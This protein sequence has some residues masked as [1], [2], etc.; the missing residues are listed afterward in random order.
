MLSI[1]FRSLIEVQISCARPRAASSDSEAKRWK[2]ESGS[3]KAV[4]RRARKRSVYHRFRSERRA[5]RET[6]KARK[7]GAASEGGA[8]GRGRGG[9]GGGW[10]PPRRGGRPVPPPRP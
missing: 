9:W 1:R 3:L 8:A 5:S 6:G 10:A 7:A 2:Y 4:E